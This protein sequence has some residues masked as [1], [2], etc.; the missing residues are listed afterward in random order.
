VK[1][2]IAERTYLFLY[3]LALLSFPFSIS[4]IQVALGLIC[5]LC[6]LVFR[7]QRERFPDGIS[8]PAG[9]FILVLITPLVAV[10]VSPDLM[11]SMKWYR[12]TLYLAMAP[13]VAITAPI[14]F[15]HW[16]KGVVLHVAACSLAGLHAIAQ[17]F[18]GTHLDRPFHPK[19]HYVHAS[20]FLSQANTFA[21]VMVFGLLTA[22]FLFSRSTRKLH[23]W[24]AALS[25]LLIYAAIV[26][27]RTRM[28][29]L[30]ATFVL[31]IFVASLF[32]K[33][34]WLAVSIFL[35]LGVLLHVSNDRLFWRFTQI[36][37]DA[38]TRIRIWEQSIRAF[39]EHWIT[40]HGLGAFQRYLEK[41][42]SEEDR[43]LA[44]FD[45]SHSNLLEAAS[46]SGLI[47]LLV[48]LLFWGRILLDMWRSFW[49]EKDPA[50]RNGF[51]MLL[52]MA[53][54][55]HLEGLTECT[56]MDAEVAMQLYFWI[57]TF[58]AARAWRE[59]QVEQLPVS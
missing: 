10:W 7:L 44:R 12:R 26:F 53:V 8:F 6:P 14:I 55:F 25:I 56:L 38:G 28:P 20:G 40:G 47:G 23:R 57:G 24:L 35:L 43:D 32:G 18:F 31:I 11:E 34:G 58:Y 17:V 33:R 39:E 27:A 19:G 45:H 49:R 13:A 2:R 15:R 59:R 9:W 5:I 29:I 54:A 22:L 4:G 50:W 30:A 41:H 16:K 37:R 1:T 3:A 46:G 21:E 36:E 51:L 52:L 48:F 42:T